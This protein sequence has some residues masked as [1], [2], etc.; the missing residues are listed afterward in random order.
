MLSTTFYAFAAICTVV[1]IIQIYGFVRFRSMRHLVVIQKRYP[2]LVQLECIAC[3][4]YIFIAI[5]ALVDHISNETRRNL[6][7][8]WQLALTLASRISTMIGS[9]FIAD[10]ESARLLLMSYDLQYLHSSRNEKWKVQIDP[11]FA[12]KDWYL[13]NKSTWGNQSFV[14]RGALA[15]YLFAI[16]VTVSV[17]TYTEVVHKE[18]LFVYVVVDAILFM[19]PLSIA[20]YTFLNLPRNLNDNLYFLF[21]YKITAIVWCIGFA[22]YVCAAVVES[23]NTLIAGTIS[24]SAGV[25][26]LSAP[27]ILSTVW[28]PH[29]IASSALW[30][31][32]CVLSEPNRLLPDSYH[33]S[34]H[35]HGTNLL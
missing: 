24:C 20:L 28:I 4:L 27:S 1:T 5:P 17:Y 23:W 35:G 13:R 8:S 21:E 22:L 16:L 26:A 33:L 19:L 34:V 3:A 15:Y 14:C 11:S 12:A 29:K 32:F 31:C 9:H 25:F 6:D 30:V 2:L 10:I 7:S 18:Y